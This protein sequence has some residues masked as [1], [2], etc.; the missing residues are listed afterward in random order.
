MFLALSGII[1]RSREEVAQA[2]SSYAASVGGGLLEEDAD[3]AHDNFCVLEEAD[4]NTTVLYP[5]HFPGW[6]DASAFLSKELKAPV[7]SFHIH[8]GDLWMYVL[9][10]D[11]TVVDQF[12]PVPDYWEEVSAEEEESWKGAARIVARYVPGLEAQSIEHYLTRWDPDGEEAKAYADDAYGQEDWQLLDFMRKLR[13][14]YPLDDDG[15]ARG[16][17]YKLWTRE[18]P[19]NE[20]VSREKEVPQAATG[21]RQKPWWKFW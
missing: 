11:G 1:G 3:S 15:K 20:E 8:D 12:N 17:V 4:G 21:N 13:L 6:D 19:L 14:P 5:N 9:Y 2:L 18:H 10:A 16:T 7:F